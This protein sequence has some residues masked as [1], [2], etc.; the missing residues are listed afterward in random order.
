M[1]LKLYFAV[2][3]VHD[4]DKKEWAISAGYIFAMDKERVLELLQNKYGPVIL[5]AL[6][7]IKIEE[8]KVLY[9]KRWDMI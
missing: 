5:H 1:D 9:G 2:F 3:S 7:D 8:G 4:E 6:N